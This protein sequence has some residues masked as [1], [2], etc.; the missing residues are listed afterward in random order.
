MNKI[1]KN[2]TIKKAFFVGLIFLCLFSV[3]LAQ[4]KEY[5]VLE[6]L[7]GIGEGEGGTVTL[8]D[9]L[10]AVF[11]LTIGIAAVLAFIVITWGG[12]TYATS[13]ALS[14]K[15]DGKKHIE[16]GIYGLLLVIGAWVILYTINPQILN[17]DLILPRSS[18]AEQSSSS[19]ASGGGVGCRGGDCSHSYSYTNSKGE[20]VTI[21]YKDCFG[22]VP[23]NSFGL[24]IKTKTINGTEAQ[25]NT[26]IGNSLKSVQ[27]SLGSGNTF[28]VTETWPPTVNHQEQG[29][30]DGTSV[31]VS[32]NN[33]TVANIKAFISAADTNGLIAQYE[34]KNETDRQNL[35]KQGV[36][37]VSIITVGYITAGHLSVYKKK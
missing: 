7:P 14:G 2:I 33:P 22:C 27:G 12:I 6:P 35:I 18:I 28:K 15:A 5:A 25:L 4:T 21:N 11:N 19:G 31:D 10:P 23:A 9:Y 13:D 17:F 3:S 16:N 36:P 32:L 29:Q 30:Y 37:A 1:K 20:V 26:G 34:V 8:Q 24:D